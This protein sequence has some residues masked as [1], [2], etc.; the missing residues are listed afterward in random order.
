MKSLYVKQLSRTK[1]KVGLVEV[2]VMILIR[3]D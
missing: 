3:L 1:T 2:H